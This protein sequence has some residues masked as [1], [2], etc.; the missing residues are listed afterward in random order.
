MPMIT[1]TRHTSGPL[2]ID[3]HHMAPE[4]SPP[5]SSWSRSNPQST[6]PS[7]TSQYI[8]KITS[9]NE[10]LKRELR[11]EK[12]AR[13]DETKRLSAARSKSEESRAEHQSLQ[14][15][16]DTNSRALERKERKLEEMTAQLEAETKRRKMA[17][18]RAEEA[19][20]MLGDTRSETQRQLAAAYEQKHLA[21]TNS[22]TAREGYKRMT[23]GYEKRMLRIK[24][25]L[26]QLRQERIEDA[27]NIRRHA[28]VSDQLQHELVRH[29][30]NENKLIDALDQYKREHRREVDALMEEAQRASSSLPEKEK[31]A[32][33]ILKEL[34]ETLDKMKWVM[35]QKRRQ[36]GGGAN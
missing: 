4:S 35:A 21:E 13:E 27:D 7:K 14:I 15:L 1:S 24:E 17:E 3:N 8:D 22:Q 31:E 10:R 28:I 12:L 34:R 29:Q 16:V 9:E 32:E 2:A 23:D 25:E 33:A 36:D 20:K 5:P 11:A 18:Q 26:N 30:R 6:A 19:L